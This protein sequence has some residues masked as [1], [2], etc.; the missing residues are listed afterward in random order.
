MCMSMLTV[1][2]VSL[3]HF[4]WPVFFGTGRYKGPLPRNCGHEVHQRLIGKNADGSFRTTG[5][6]CCG[7]GM[8]LDL[9]KLAFYHWLLAPDGTPSGGKIFTAVSVPGFAKSDWVCKAR[10]H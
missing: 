8:C 4:G 9:A 3:L 6:G 5:S 1:L 7:P 10:L 2:L